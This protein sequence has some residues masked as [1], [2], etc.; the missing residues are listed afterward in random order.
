[1]MATNWITSGLFLDLLSWTNLIETIIKMH[2]AHFSF[3]KMLLKR[4][5]AKW[6]PFCF[7]L[8][9]LK[10]NYCICFEILLTY[11]HTTLV[12]PL[13]VEHNFPL[14]VLND[15]R[16]IKLPLNLQTPKWQSKSLYVED[17]SPFIPQ[18]HHHDHGHWRNSTGTFYLSTRS[19]AI[20]D[21]IDFDKRHHK[22]CW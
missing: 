15:F 8:N 1:M 19:I 16:V 20:K 2:D 4:S 7:D 9:V 3:T 13:S 6:R 22:I 12:I 10:E 17:K 14:Y 11:M 5:Y 21:Y 18:I